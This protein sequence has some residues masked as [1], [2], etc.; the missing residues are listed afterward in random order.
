[1]A[2]ARISEKAL[3]IISFS[4]SFEVHA[5]PSSGRLEFSYDEDKKAV[6]AFLKAPPKGGKANSELL[7]ALSKISGKKFEIISGASSRNKIIKAVA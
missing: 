3:S 5:R 1:M 7:R 6:I 2:K 4:S